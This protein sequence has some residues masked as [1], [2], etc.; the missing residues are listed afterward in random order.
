MLGEVP[1]VA[2]RINGAVRMLAAGALTHRVC[3]DGELAGRCLT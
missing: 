1:V 2:T 3:S